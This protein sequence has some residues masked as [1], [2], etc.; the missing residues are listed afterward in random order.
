MRAP[1]KLIC[2]A[3]VAFGV[4]SVLADYASEIDFK[5]ASDMRFG[6]PAQAVTEPIELRLSPGAWIDRAFCLSQGQHAVMTFVAKANRACQDDLATWEKQE[7]RLVFDLPKGVTLEAVSQGKIASTRATA[8]GT[9]VECVLDPDEAR[10]ICRQF[11]D[12][13]WWRRLG[14]LVAADAHPLSPERVM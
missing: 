14:Y 9:H 7:M 8:G 11:D 4:V 12:F 6:S 3:C 1:A 13:Y 10:I 5:A 2:G